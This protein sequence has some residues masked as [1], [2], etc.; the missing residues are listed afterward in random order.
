MV[1]SCVWLGTTVSR[2]W[3]LKEQQ[4]SRDRRSKKGSIIA[5]AKLVDRDDRIVIV[6]SLQVEGNPPLII[7]HRSTF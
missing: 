7:L 3:S 2:G 4:H 1:E 6:K 5:D